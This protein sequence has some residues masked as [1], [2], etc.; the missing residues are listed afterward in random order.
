[1]KHSALPFG[2]PT[3]VMGIVNVTPDSFHDGGRHNTVDAAIEHGLRLVD[4]GALVLDIGGESTRPGAA[5][6]SEAEELERVLPVL[7][8]LKRRV[9]V[10][11]SVDTWKASVAEQALAAGADWINDISGGV[12]DPRIL[13]VVA[14]AGVPYVAMHMRGTPATMQTLTEYDDLIAEVKAYFV[15]RL[16]AFE[17]AGGQREMLILDPG[18]GFAKKPSDNY[19]LLANLAEFRELG[20]P[21]LVGPSRKSFLKL[22]GGE[23]TADRLPGT[24][25]AI[26]ICALAGVEVVRVHDVA[27]TVQAV[28]VARRVLAGGR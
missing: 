9:N 28:N 27:E 24:M 20:L 16:Q 12:R 10:P 22:A 8:A 17:A 2:S 15:D 11:V 7:S 4:E 19:T 25:A 1:M 6:V 14:E 5:E 26:T 23:D 3:L 21:L 18:I 13:S